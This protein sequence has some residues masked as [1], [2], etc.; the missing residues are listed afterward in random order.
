MA[1]KFE[2][3][4][5]NIIKELLR[6]APSWISC[7]QLAKAILGDVDQSEIVA[8]IV[9]SRSDIFL[10]GKESFVKLKPEAAVR[11]HPQFQKSST[12]NRPQVQ[13]ERAVRE[14]ISHLHPYQLKVVE[15]DPGRRVLE[16][17]VYGLTV[18][19]SDDDIKLPD[20]TPVEL[21]YGGGSRNPG[22]VVGASRDE[23]I[24]YV[25]LR[26]EVHPAD[27][28]AILEVNK[29]Q[30]LLYIASR[31]AALNE[32]PPLWI[33]VNAVTTGH[34]MGRENSRDLAGDLAAMSGQWVRLLWGP[35]GAGKTHCIAAFCAGLLKADASERILVVAP[36]N[37]AV[38]AA[39][40][41]I[42]SA[43]EKDSSCDQLVSQR[44]VFRYGY[45]RLEAVL[46]KSELFGPTELSKLSE[47]IFDAYKTIKFLNE[48]RAPERDIA[49]AQAK[50]KQLQETRKQL[51]AT[52]LSNAN[53]VATTLSAAF[54]GTNPVADSGPW[55]TVVVD[56]ASMVS[57]ANILLL[58]AL[59]QKRFLIVG[60]PRQLAPIFE[61]SH[62]YARPQNLINWLAMD[63]YEVAGLAKGSLWSK[64][65]T[66]EDGRIARLLS[67]RRCHPR[68]WE[69]SARLYPKVFSA[70]DESRLDS[71]AALPPLPGEPA[72][73][74][75]LSAG[76]QANSEVAD[77]DSA[78]TIAVDYES[79]CRKVGR[80][81]E[82]PPTAM[83]ALD[84]AREIRAINSNLSI[85]IICPYRGQVR[86]IRRWLHGESQADTRLKGVEV[87]TVHSFQGGEA[88]VVI[89]D[90][91]DGPPRPTM[92][93]L[94]R[95]ETGMRL[96][97][98]AMTRA[99]GK[100]IL[101]AHKKWMSGVDPVRSGLLW[102]AVF[103]GNAPKPCYVLPPSLA[104]DGWTDG[105]HEGRKTES[106]IEEILLAELKRR[107]NTFPK[108]ILQYRIYDENSR[109]VSRAD[110]AFEKERLAVFCDGAKYHLK[111]DQWRRDLRQRRELTR[112]GWQH[113][114]FSGSEITSDVSRCVDEIRNIL[115]KNGPWGENGD[116]SN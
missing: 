111:R 51:E 18:E 66:T 112:L 88:D 60:D 79:A 62:A 89:F 58:A 10:F 110:L 80:S 102:N 13:A 55:Q 45:P 19:I 98:V 21:V 67:Q 56:E 24:L 115:Q 113:L 107:E 109:I 65:V 94:L 50:L 27:L 114:A 8:S 1:D 57:G 73:M 3:L 108:F 86:L 34:S 68:I 105:T 61:W 92:G 39:V 38:D 35:P 46:S 103:G 59:A 40:L 37:V 43:L 25:A 44:K 91:V 83:L 70:V 78:P 48:K 75:D 31:L 12:D 72:V 64:E 6:N 33:S 52:Y 74:L 76:R 14:Y 99:R 16:R 97:N 23:M 29:S 30:P 96:A 49:E 5:D 47:E 15:T 20:D 77:R 71:I 28:P 106:P 101:I 11:F 36:S 2:Q 26:Y 104:R 95:D 63:P 69:L 4:T 100:L 84:V 42:V 54:T 32:I 90:I 7:R 87:G 9:A 17:Y 116:K 22:H 93:A 85:A 53:V 41:E 82:N 81:W